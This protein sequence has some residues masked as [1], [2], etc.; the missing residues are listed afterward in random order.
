MNKYTK[1]HTYIGKT[2]N[3]LTVAVLVKI[4]TENCKRDTFTNR[5]TASVFPQTDKHINLQT[6]SKDSDSMCTNSM[7]TNR[8]LCKAILCVQIDNFVKR[9]YVYK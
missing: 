8:Q 4:Y 9:Y 7:C 1:I 2:A 3:S 5:L 6:T